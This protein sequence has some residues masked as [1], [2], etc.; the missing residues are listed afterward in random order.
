MLTKLSYII[1]VVG[2]VGCICLTVAYS[3]Q[4]YKVFQSKRTD[5]L[6]FSF[7]ILV[8]VA[9][10]LFGVYG[11]LQIG[12]SPTIIVGI[13]NGLAIMISNF[14]ASL[15]SVVMLVYKIINYNKAKK[16]QLSE[17]A[18]YEQM[19]APFLNQQTKQNEGNK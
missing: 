8:S 19:V 15:L 6:S 4:T 1:T 12:L 18:Y 14:I 3:F 11:A 7:L 17:K 9:C 5:G 13:Q 16:H 2:V 10:F